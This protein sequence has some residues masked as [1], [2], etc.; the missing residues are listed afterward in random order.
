MSLQEVPDSILGAWRGDLERVGVGHG[1]ASVCDQLRP[2]GLGLPLAARHPL[3]LVERHA[4]FLLSATPVDPVKGSTST[5]GPSG[6]RRR[7]ERNDGD[8][9]IEPSRVGVERTK[10]NFRST[11]WLFGRAGSPPSATT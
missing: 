8:E 5:L 7:T 1:L 2:R 11:K 9:V 10:T 4:H 3:R 6:H